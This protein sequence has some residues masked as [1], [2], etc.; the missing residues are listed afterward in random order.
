MYEGKQATLPNFVKLAHAGIAVF[1]THG[2][3]HGNV[4]VERKR[5]PG[6]LLHAYSKYLDAGYSPADIEGQ[7]FSE[8]AGK[9]KR[10][11]HGLFLTPHGIRHFFS[12]RHVPLVAAIACDSLQDA[13]YF[14]ARAYFGYTTCARIIS[15][16]G[17]S[18]NVF[19]RMTG[20]AGV[21][22]SRA[23][24]HLQTSRPPTGSRWRAPTGRSYFR[25]RSCRSRRR[26]ALR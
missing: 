1:F 21:D 19:G 17:D 5:T 24:R 26:P 22:G 16:L 2:G 7:S 8:G 15:L 12:G 20:I 11:V 18:I 13:K 14:Q 9:A 10:D 3:E 23:R 4:L 25:L 6:G